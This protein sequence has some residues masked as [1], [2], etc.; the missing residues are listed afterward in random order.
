MFAPSFE[1]PESADGSIPVI[2]VPE[3]VLAEREAGV[4]GGTYGGF[5]EEGVYQVGVYARDEVGNYARPRWVQ[6]GG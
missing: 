6:I 2:E 3:V 5:T 1:A 4:F